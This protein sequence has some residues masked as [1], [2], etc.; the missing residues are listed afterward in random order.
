MPIAVLA[1]VTGDKNFNLD[2]LTFR[3]DFR[4]VS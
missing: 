3:N 4:I 1:K 2:E